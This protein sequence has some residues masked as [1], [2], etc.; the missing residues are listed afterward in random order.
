VV[1]QSGS[2]DPLI[3]NVPTEQP[4]LRA[5]RAVEAAPALEETALLT[6]KVWHLALVSMIFVLVFWHFVLHLY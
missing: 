3:V 5:P 2:A 1:V 4:R 6:M